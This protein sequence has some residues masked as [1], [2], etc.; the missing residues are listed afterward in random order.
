MFSRIFCLTIVLFISKTHFGQSN[1]NSH[2]TP[3]DSLKMLYNKGKA[4]KAYSAFK[5]GEALWFERKSHESIE[6]L[7][8][9]LRHDSIPSKKNSVLNANNLLANAYFH[10][11]DLEIAQQYVANN[12]VHFKKFAH[13]PLEGN[14]YEIK[15]R[16]NLALGRIDE[17]IE[18]FIKA[19][20]LD[21][22][23]PEPEIKKL[24]VYIKFILA[25]CFM[26]Q[27]Q[28]SISKKYLDGAYSKAMEYKDDALQIICLRSLGNW[29]LKNKQ[30]KQAYDKFLKAYNWDIPQ[31]HKLYAIHGLANAEFEMKAYDKALSHYLI[32]LSIAKKMNET[33]MLSK[34]YSDMGNA[35]N[36]VNRKEEAIIYLDSSLMFKNDNLVT[37]A[38]ALKRKANVLFSMGQYKFAY[39]SLNQYN[40]IVDSMSR[41]KVAA[42][43]NKLDII[44]ETKKK[45]LAIKDLQMDVSL[46]E[47][48]IRKDKMIKWLLVII[49][50]MGLGIFYYYYLQ[51]KA[52]RKYENQIAILEERSRI[53][54]DLHDDIGST[55]S[56]LQ[57]NSELAE[58]YFKE[59]PE[60]SIQLIAK[61]AQ[62]SAGLSARIGDIIWSLKP[63]P[64]ASSSIQS[65]LLDYEIELFQP[66]NIRCVYSIDE[67]L[68]AS[69]KNP[70]FRKNI[71]LIIKEA[72]NNIAK[73]SRA[74]NA[75]IEI[76]KS[77]NT[78]HVIINDDGIGFD[79]NTVKKGNGLHNMQRRAELLSGTYTIHSGLETG[80][81]ISIN[82]PL[83]QKI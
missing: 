74:Q 62:N 38:E 23:S 73:Y 35:L 45:N 44:H 65:K 43:T 18:D 9:S 78:L 34:F 22:A 42:L 25:D 6:W 15:G 21:E 26:S 17:S 24:A 80:T 79:I 50:F 51:Q 31:N 63:V 66:K 12:S 40:S 61:V 1:N 54:S 55:L 64:D 83:D 13:H 14:L 41:G 27:G 3:T 29:H 19:D 33:Y 67:T 28:D 5:V 52:K 11:G 10:L 30:Y 7:E 70:L 53:I 56:S 58:K 76:H 72:M 36:M 20:S 71:L 16:I 37:Y 49:F 75:K 39:N 8:R 47:K 81:S 60:K 68:M 4:D 82:I 46:K 59:K 32:A 77:H 69:V 48:T 2:P 57:I